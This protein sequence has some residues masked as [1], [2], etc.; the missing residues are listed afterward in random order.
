MRRVERL[1]V[2]RALLWLLLADLAVALPLVAAMH[3]GADAGREDRTDLHLFRD[4]AGTIL[5]GDW[6]YADT[7]H[8]TLT[9][10]LINYI[11][12]VP[13]L[14]GDTL[15][16]WEVYL[17]LW[18]FAVG[19]VLFLG[20][21]TVHRGLAFT[22]SLVYVTSPFGY[23]TSV[24][25]VQDDTIVPVFV[26]AS[27]VLLLQ[28]HHIRSGFWSGLG[29][30]VKAWPG[31]AAP[32][33]F[34]S[35]PSWRVRAQV[36]AAGAGIA[37][38]I[39]LPFLLFVPDAF[40][41]FLRFYLLGKPPDGA[42]EGLSLWRFLW[43]AGLGVPQQ[44]NLVALLAGLSFIW[45]HT[46]RRGV[47][48]PVGFAASYLALLVAYPKLHF[49]YYL[50]GLLVALPWAATR[51]RRL[52][53]LLAASGVARLAHLYWREV[54]PVS[55]GGILVAVALAV[56]LVAYWAWWLVTV[57]NEGDFRTQWRREPAPGAAPGAPGPGALR[58]D[59]AQLGAG[60]A[61]G[62]AE[63]PHAAVAASL[64]VGLAQVA[65]ALVAAGVSMGT[66]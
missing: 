1:P 61:G 10:P 45:W 16:A 42:F 55:G 44:A 19:A 56:A 37:L 26:A 40:G 14:A 8:V 27:F 47:A 62:A 32:V 36:A 31:I 30:M 6:L 66:P 28:A 12:T 60:A 7:D 18:T 43:L 46:W 24:A 4:R 65:I 52:L 59:V 3:A 57:W 38:L 63:P 35:A 58:A 22:T 11:L 64:A 21:R 33:I 9:P 34:L 53:G 48:P 2:G 20:L 15:V 50:L 23:T 5:E 13:M 17:S 49:G 25:M 41:D 29:T 51:W 39:S 54:I